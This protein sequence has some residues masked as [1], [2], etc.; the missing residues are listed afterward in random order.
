MNLNN[1]KVTGRDNRGG[2]DDPAE[3]Y[4]FVYFNDESRLA[5]TSDEGVTDVTGGWGEVT[6][7]HM[8][9]ARRFLLKDGVV[10]PE[11]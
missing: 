11:E 9:L 5:Y 2:S 4:G 8:Q 6:S 10:L 3:Q 7:T 1:L